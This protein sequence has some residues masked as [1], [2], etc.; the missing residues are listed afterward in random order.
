MT[1][2]TRNRLCRFLA[3]LAI[4]FAVVTIWGRMGLPTASAG[5]VFGLPLRLDYVIG[6]LFGVGFTR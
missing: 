1:T 3:I 4:A 5:H 6:F 2:R